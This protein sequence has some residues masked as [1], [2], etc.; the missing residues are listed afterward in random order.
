MVIICFFVWRSF[1]KLLKCLRQ[2]SHCILVNCKKKKKTTPAKILWLVWTAE[3]QCSQPDLLPHWQH[4]GLKP[5][6]P[7]CWCLIRQVRWWDSPTV[8]DVHW[9]ETHTPVM[10]VISSHCVTLIHGKEQGTTLQSLSFFMCCIQGSNFSIWQESPIR[11]LLT[12]K[13]HFTSVLTEPNYVIIRGE[14]NFKK[15]DAMKWNKC[16]YLQ[17]I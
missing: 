1:R 9:S 2:N 17:L 16:L 8:K 11:H 15:T 10:L 14:V 5:S 3:H 13:L 12:S 4:T 6:V 7:I